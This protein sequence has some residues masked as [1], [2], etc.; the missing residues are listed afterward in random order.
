[1]GFFNRV[2][3]AAEF[4]AYVDEY[5]RRIAAVSP[6]SVAT[7]KRQLWADLLHNDPAAAVVESKRLIGVAMKQPDYAEGVAAFLEKRPPRFT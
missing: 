5:A 2:L 1:M 3:P 6:S 4:P 7:T